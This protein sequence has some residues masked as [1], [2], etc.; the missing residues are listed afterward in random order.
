MEGLSPPTNHPDQPAG[1]VRGAFA[2]ALEDERDAYNARFAQARRVHRQLDAAAFSTHLVDN[3]APMIDALAAHDKARVDVA[4]HALFELSCDLVARRWLG[5]QVRTDLL[6]RLW[7]DILPQLVGFWADAPRDVVLSLTCAVH[8]LDDLAPSAAESWMLRLPA[9]AP[10]CTDT[11]MLLD[12]GKVLAWRAGL[13]HFRDS[14]LQV[15]RTLPAELRYQTLCLAR[16]DERALLDPATRPA[17][18]MLD[19]ALE[20]PWFHPTFHLAGADAKTRAARSGATFR[21]VGGFVGFGAQFGA[22][23]RVFAIDGQLVAFDGEHCFSIHA[24]AFGS[25]LKKR[26]AEPPAGPQ[27]RVGAERAEA[28]GQLDLGWATP[29]QWSSITGREDALLDAAS[30][31]TDAWTLAVC[32]PHS[33]QIFLISRYD[34]HYAQ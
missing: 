12:A 31:A 9:L 29:E 19:E 16:A 18:D 32:V 20:D 17:L 28:S 34:R 7:R 21:M 6:N 1:R 2:A 14:A 23:P 25:V 13:A 24:D 10:L 27:P 30:A 3:L 22:P 33:H 8:H 4:T 11:R 5:P 26:D 15:W